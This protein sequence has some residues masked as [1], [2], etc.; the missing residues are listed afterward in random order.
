MRLIKGEEIISTVTQFCKSQ[1]IMSGELL[2]IGAVEK[3]ELGF[4]YLDRKEYEWR[5]FEN[6][7]EIV[8]LTGNIALVDG[9]PFLHIHTVLSDSNF[10]TVGGHM[11]E[12]VVGATCE[13]YLN[14]FE[15]NLTRIFDDITG[16]KLIEETD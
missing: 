14:K 6:P 4:Y 3:A 13:I 10:Q 7:M 5:K 2:G 16:L 9:E 1:N 15:T 11:K 8:S 12:G